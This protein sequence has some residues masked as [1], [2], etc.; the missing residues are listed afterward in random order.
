MGMKQTKSAMWKIVILK[1]KDINDFCI[2]Q[3]LWYYNK[4]KSPK[5]L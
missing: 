1:N 5:R 4:L 2:L 3:T